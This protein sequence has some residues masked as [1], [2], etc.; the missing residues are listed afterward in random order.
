MTLQENNKALV[1]KAFHIW[2]SGNMKGF[3]EVYAPNCINHQLNQQTLR[4]LDA[5]KKL[6]QDFRHSFPDFQDTIESQ[7]A[8]GNFVVTRFTSK[9]THK[10]KFMDIAPTNK[11]CQWSGIIIDRI[12]NNKIVESWVNWDLCALLEQLGALHMHAIH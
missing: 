6:V 4:G 8:E 1:K 10:G 5:W 2:S 7:I 12:E 11:K 9:G 3:E